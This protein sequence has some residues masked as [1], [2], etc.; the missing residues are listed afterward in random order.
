MKILH[1]I[2]ARGGSKG[3]PNKNVRVLAGHSLVGWK[4]LAARRSRHCARLVISTES[5]AI[6]DEA[7]K[8]EVEVPFTRPAELASDTATSAD[9]IAH[10][11]EHFESKG[12]RY[13][14]IMLLE[15]SS[16]F[17]TADDLDGAVALYVARKANAV[18]GMRLTEVSTTFIAPKTDDGNIGVIV[19]RIAHRRATARQDMAPEWTMNGGLY[20]FGWDYFRT[21]KNI[22]ADPHGTY[23]YLMPSERSLEIDSMHDMHYAEFLV[24]RGLVQPPT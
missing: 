24:E 21:H 8:Y 23:G 12:E 15:P 6:A 22:Y 19:E 17:T 14:A 10:A 9:V 18:V 3:V 1:L 16:P 4:A 20:L 2:T 7:R 5:A 11:I 13:D